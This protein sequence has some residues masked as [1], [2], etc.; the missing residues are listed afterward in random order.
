MRDPT[1][2]KAADNLAYTNSLMAAIDIIEQNGYEVIDTFAIQYTPEGGF[3]FQW[4]DISEEA[5]QKREK[6]WRSNMYI[7]DSKKTA[8]EIYNYLRQRYQIPEEM[9]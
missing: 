5:A 9:P 1:R 8:E 7:P 2:N 6:N 3:A 4:G